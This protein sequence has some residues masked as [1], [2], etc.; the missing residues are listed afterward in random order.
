MSEPSGMSRIFE[1][2]TFIAEICEQE[3]IPYA[4]AG[5][6]AVGIWAEPRTTFD[7]DLVLGIPKDNAEKLADQLNNSGRFP[8]DPI[9]LPFGATSVV[10]VHRLVR[11]VTENI[12]ILIDLLLYDAEFS[13]SISANRGRYT[14]EGVGEFWFCSAEDLII[15]KLIASR[16]RDQLDIFDIFDARGDELDRDYIQT[17]AQHFQCLDQ[18]TTWWNEWKAT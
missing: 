11:G 6:L 5:G 10:R 13:A 9:V 8:F 17:W 14:I 3:G 2:L 16:R 15:M 4:I 18:W 1:T 12:I 7:V